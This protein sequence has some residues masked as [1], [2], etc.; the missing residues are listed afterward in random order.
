MISSTIVETLINYR[1]YNFFKRTNK[2][3][4][5]SG[6]ILKFVISSTMIVKDSHK[7]SHREYKF[8]E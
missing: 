4:K 2:K 7:L 5:R 1:E 8:F 3:K 6:I